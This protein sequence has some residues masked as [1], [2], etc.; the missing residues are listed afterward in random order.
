MV[1]TP[2]N[3]AA[4]AIVN[5]PQPVIANT[6]TPQPV[7]ANNSMPHPVLTPAHVSVVYTQP[8]RQPADST[9]AARSPCEE[10]MH[11]TDLE[12]QV[13][14]QLTDD[15]IQWDMIKEIK[16]R[17]I[18]GDLDIT[19][20]DGVPLTAIE[21]KMLAECTNDTRGWF[22]TAATTQR[23]GLPGVP[24]SGGV[25]ANPGNAVSMALD[26]AQWGPTPGSHGSS[27]PG[28][29]GN[30]LEPSLLDSLGAPATMTSRQQNSPSPPPPPATANPR[31]ARKTLPTPPHSTRASAGPTDFGGAI[32]ATLAPPPGFGTPRTTFPSTVETHPPGVDTHAQPAG[33]RFSISTKWV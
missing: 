19:E 15:D 26:S 24:G 3:P 23:Q 22:M 21:A 30:R 27:T 7:L 20:V 10:G 1:P 33:T 5:A 16:A 12:R 28:S 9:W 32:A 6:S 8:S 13:L 14:Q 11:C 18:D 4:V 25:P 31:K 17:G 29:H 2:S